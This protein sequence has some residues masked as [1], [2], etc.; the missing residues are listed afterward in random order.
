MSE[1]GGNE[2]IGSLG[3]EATKLLLALQGWAKT[4]GSDYADATA[5]AATHAA[6]VLG[7]VNEHIATG[8][9]DCRYCPLC[10]AISTVRET[11]PEVKEHLSSAASSLLQAVAGVMDTRIPDRSGNARTDAAMEKI[12]LADDGTWEDD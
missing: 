12:D 3:E 6:S 10:R 4:S 2:S 5:G 11:S 1:D 8:G 7:E 9:E